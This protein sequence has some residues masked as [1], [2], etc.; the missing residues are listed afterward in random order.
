MKEKI[1][2]DAS[3]T[4]L[5]IKLQNTLNENSETND[6]WKSFLNKSNAEFILRIVKPLYDKV[7]FEFHVGE[8]KRHEI[9]HMGIVDS[10]QMSALRLFLI[11][12]TIIYIL[13]NL[14][15]IN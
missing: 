8:I 4:D 11:L 2:Y 3:N 12:D 10:D 5:R 15:E 6:V 7:N 13:D 14:D 1:D 9:A